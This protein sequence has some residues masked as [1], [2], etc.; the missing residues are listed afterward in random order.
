M[1]EFEFKLE[2]HIEIE[3]KTIKINANSDTNENS[4][5]VDNHFELMQ[6]M[7]KECIF[8]DREVNIPLKIEKFNGIQND[9]NR[10]IGK[11]RLK[12]LKDKI[13]KIIGVII[14]IIDLRQNMSYVLRCL[15]TIQPTYLKFN[16]T[17]TMRELNSNPKATQLSQLTTSLESLNEIIKINH[18]NIMY[19]DMKDD[20]YFENQS[21]GL[22]AMIKSFWNQPHKHHL[23]NRSDILNEIYEFE[24]HPYQSYRAYEFIDIKRSNEHRI[25]LDFEHMG[26]V[27]KC[28]TTEKEA[29]ILN[30]KHQSKVDPKELAMVN[31]VSSKI[32]TYDEIE[33]VSAMIKEYHKTLNSLRYQKEIEKYDDLY[34]SHSEKGRTKF[35]DSL[36]EVE[37]EL[38]KCEHELQ[39]ILKRKNNI[40]EY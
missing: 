2:G 19:V 17:H 20:M 12:Q 31:H 22:I 37:K 38:E 33:T 30:T 1:K 3:N 26:R 21:K 8:E 34:A 11:V 10:L 25:L 15:T 35:Q 4:L 14:H 16:H 28:I 39:N 40:K 36:S 5:K 29:D 32:M 27:S 7:M 6:Y 24:N 9:N 13:S 23:L 18:L